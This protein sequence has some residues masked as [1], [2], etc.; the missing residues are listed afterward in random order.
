M[1]VSELI[2]IIRE[3]CDLWLEEKAE[4]RQREVER[5]LVDELEGV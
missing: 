5:D 2:D 3:E 4:A 1:T